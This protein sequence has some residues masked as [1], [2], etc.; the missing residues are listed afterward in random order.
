MSRERRFLV[1]ELAP[2]VELAG[3]EAHHLLHV[4]RLGVGDEVV[5]FDGRGRASRAVV[6]GCSQSSAS[7][8]TLDEEPSRESYLHLALGVAALK[9]DKMATVVQKLTELGV[10]R[11]LPFLAERGEVPAARASGG[12]ARWRRVALEASK[13]SG[14]SLVPE[15][16]EPRDLRSLLDAEAASALFVAHPGAPSIA[17]PPAGA[18]VLALVGPEGGLSDAEIAL[19][20]RRGARRFGLGPRTLR[21]ETA[22]IV[23]AALLQH[24]AGDLASGP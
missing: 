7:L 1:G 6:T 3:H 19:A 17:F 18:S 15:I 5:L 9:A 12:L 4:L 21:A 10:T 14:R 8:E 23:V 22:A 20:E 2:R 11:I 16:A 24:G 13:Q